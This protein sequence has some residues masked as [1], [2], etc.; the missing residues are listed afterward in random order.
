MPR[1]HLDID[2]CLGVDVLDLVEPW[3]QFSVFENRKGVVGRVQGHGQNEHERQRG[4]HQQAA[5]LYIVVRIE[6][7]CRPHF[8]LGSD[9]VKT[10]KHSK[11]VCVGPPHPPNT[12]GKDYVNSCP[13]GLPP[14]RRALSERER[15]IRLRKIESFVRLRI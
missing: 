9:N 11:E 8:L 6:N 1:V 14:L 7:T 2:V 13:C 15:S 12:M 4:E 3:L 5:I 10:R